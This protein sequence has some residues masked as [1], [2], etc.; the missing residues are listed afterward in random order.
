MKICCIFPPHLTD[1]STLPGETGNPEIVS[2]YFNDVCCFVN[3]HTKHIKILPSVSKR[4]T[5]CTRQDL[6]EGN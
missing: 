4:L 5:L 2:F 1:V 6:Q 3:I